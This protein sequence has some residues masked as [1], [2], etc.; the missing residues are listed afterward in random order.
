[1]AVK[2]LITSFWD[3][4]YIWVSW[5]ITIRCMYYHFKKMLIILHKGTKHVIFFKGRIS[6]PDLLNPKVLLYTRAHHGWGNK[7]AKWNP[8]K[9]YLPLPPSKTLSKTEGTGVLSLSSGFWKA[10]LINSGSL[11]IINGA[12]PPMPK[13]KI[14]PYFFAILV[15]MSC[16]CSP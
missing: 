11:R 9:T 5:T 8:G 16:S 2:F 10:S 6:F 3:T 14:F 4:Q 12:P 7:M 1:M 13:E 15:I